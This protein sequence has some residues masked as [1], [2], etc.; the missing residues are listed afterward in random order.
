MA[1]QDD[2]TKFFGQLYLYIY[3]FL[4]KLWDNPKLSA[5]ILLAADKNEVKTHLANFI[6]NNFYENCLSS[7]GKEDQLL[8]IITLLLKVEVNNL[9]S[10]KGNAFEFLIDETN[11]CLYIFNELIH[12]KELQSYFKNIILEVTKKIEMAFSRDKILFE[13]E[14][15]SKLLKKSSSD[16]K[17]LINRFKRVNSLSDNS[18]FTP[19]TIKEIESKCLECKNKD[20]KT[21]LK[22]KIE[23]FA[24]YPKIYSNEE[25]LNKIYKFE[26]S[27]QVLCHYSQSFVEV[28]NIINLLLDNLLFYA[29]SLPYYIKCI[30]KIII[31]FIEKKYPDSN[32]V[33]VN[34]FM[35]KFFFDNL[36]FKFFENP[37]INCLINE[38]LIT[39]KTM[40]I[41]NIIKP[42]LSKF[43]SGEFFVETDIFVTFNNLFIEKM[44]KLFEFYDIINKTK[45]PSFIH[46]LINNDLNKDYKYDYFEENP[47]ENVFYRTICI[48]TDIIYSLVINAEKCNNN[49]FKKDKALEKLISNKKKL[50]KLKNYFEDALIN[51][52]NKITYFLMIDVINNKKYDKIINMKKDKNHFSLKELKIIDDDMK[53]IEN[54]IIKAKNNFCSLLYNYPTLNKNEFKSENLKKVINILKEIKSFSKG[55]SFVKSEQSI[56]NSESFLN[57][58]LQQ[59]LPIL[60]KRNIS[61]NKLIEDKLTNICNELKDIKENINSNKQVDSEQKSIPI[62]WFLDSLIQDLPRLPHEYIEKDYDLLLKSLEKDLNKSI[63]ELDFE[64]LCQMTKNMNEIQ[65]NLL[66]Y[67]KVKNIII[68]ISLNK[69]ANEIIEKEEIPVTITLKNKKLEIKPVLNNEISGLFLSYIFQKKEEEEPKTINFFINDFPNINENLSPNEDVIKLIEEMEIPK[70]LDVYFNLVKECITQK[71]IENSDEIYNKIYDYIMERLNDKLFPKEINPIDAKIK[72][73][74]TKVVWI[75]LSNIMKTKQNIVMDHMLPDAISYFKKINEEKSPR[76]KIIYLK[77]IF[78][79][80]FNIGKFNGKKFEGVDDEMPLLN[81]IFI[82]AQ[83]ENIFD[84]CR[85]MELF[86][87]EKKDKV[88]GQ[89]VTEL[90]GLCELL[91]KY[92]YDNLYNITISE[93]E[94]NVELVKQ[95][96]L[97]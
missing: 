97:Y 8:Y 94:E 58:L 36:F 91:T 88:E 45:L 40:N 52:N 85:Y 29:D 1:E 12:K 90:K 65:Q 59:Y 60:E 21:F 13:P 96:I 18:L 87:G 25:L 63:S 57:K 70:Q 93:Y 80:I 46:K 49:E 50:E 95:G 19:L 17:E 27:L 92:S 28:K 31:F 67:K 14:E 51:N 41:L 6:T 35:L 30:C 76:K 10:K 72:E 74:C 24:K 42:I 73:N 54:N 44:P 15:I 84:N 48:N 82:K 47:E 68:D 86:L 23:Y 55:N 89:K 20:M 77:E 71:N 62:K 9:Q 69:K 56:P 64:F 61:S 83:P 66:Y 5:D 7:N 75:E 26:N 4:K 2:Q 11:P 53:R 16:K 33:V 79:C 32:K 22:E 39:E 3:P 37:E 81:Y 38:L 34:S 43:V 78:N